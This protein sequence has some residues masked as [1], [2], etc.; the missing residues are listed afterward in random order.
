MYNA[1]GTVYA[2]MLRAKY[3]VKPSLTSEVEG[4]DCRALCNNVDFDQTKDRNTLYL[5]FGGTHTSAP[6]VV[7]S[8]VFRDSLPAVSARDHNAKVHA[9]R[10]NSWHARVTQR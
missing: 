3:T 2:V 6:G 10:S 5:I 9:A 4:L 8:L 1:P 7:T